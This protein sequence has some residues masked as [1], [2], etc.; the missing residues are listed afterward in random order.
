MILVLLLLYPLAN[1]FRKKYSYFIAPVI[2]LFTL[3][4]VYYKKIDINFPLGFQRPFIN[5]FYKGLIF[6]P[7]GNIAFA[8]TEFINKFKEKFKK[9]FI[10]F[11]SIF[12]ILIYVVL[13][14]NLQFRFL[15]NSSFAYLLTINIALT[16]SGITYTSKI[17][18]HNFF[19]KLGRYGFY[20]YLC[21][22]SVRVFF[23]N[24]YNVG[25][26]SYWVLLFK[27]VFLTLLIGFIIYFIVEILYKRKRIKND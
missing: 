7:L 18:K 8:L 9:N 4:F 2:L 5:G 19:K 13:F 15:F 27:F 20:L 24:K 14:L 23:L 21:N 25:D 12:E 10:C 3:F 1:K 26:V 6:I 17:F 11:L 16:F 22:T